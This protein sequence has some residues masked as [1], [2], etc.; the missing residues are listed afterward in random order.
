[1][2][3]SNVKFV[4]PKTAAGTF[5]G[6]AGI[7]GFDSGVLLSCGN[8]ADVVGPNSSD[9]ITTDNNLPGDADL[10]KLIPGYKSYDATILEFGFIP[11]TD[12]IMF[13]YVFGSDEYNEWVNSPFNDVF[14]FFVNQVNY[15]RVAGDPVSINSING[16][17]PLG[18]NASH[19]SFYVNNWDEKNNKGGTLDTEMDGLTVELIFTAPVKRGAKNWLKLAIADA[20]DHV[21]DSNVFLR[22]GSLISAVPIAGTVTTYSGAGIKDVAMAFTASNGSDQYVVLT[23]ANGYFYSAVAPGWSGTLTPSKPGLLFKPVALSYS[24]VYGPYYNQNFIGG[25]LA[26]PDAMIRKKEDATTAYAANDVYN[27]TGEQQ[28]KTQTVSL[29]DTA[30]YLGKVE[31]DGW[32]TQTLAVTA[33]TVPAGWA[34]TYYDK[35]RGGNDVT[36][37]VTGAGG[38]ALPN[39]APGAFKEFRVEVTPDPMLVAPAA[40]DLLITVSNSGSSEQ[41]AVKAVTV[42]EAT[43]QPD[44]LIANATD[45]VYLGNDFYDTLA[46]ITGSG[47]LQTQAQAVLRDTTATY[48]L[49][50]QNDGNCLDDFR[51][52]GTAGHPA[53]TVRYYDALTGGTDI[54]AQVAGGGWTTGTLGPGDIREMR[55]EVTP[56]ASA[57]DGAVWTVIVKATSSIEA[58]CRD[59][60]RADTSV[61]A[62]HQPDMLIRTGG[63]GF[64]GGGIYNTTGAN[65]T[66]TQTRTTGAVAVYGLR[67][68]SPASAR[69]QYPYKVV[70]SASEGGW[71]VR[72]FD[73]LSG[74]TDITSL[75]T[76]AGWWTPPLVAGGTRD[77]RVEVTPHSAVPAGQS[78]EVFVIACSPLDAGIRDAVKAVTTKN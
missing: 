45:G 20:G 59:L 38:W 18:T 15:A 1:V 2:G 74:G 56:T 35:P 57:G 30:V 9:S 41:D 37:Q 16:G 78:K 68:Q 25:P 31:N 40:Y 28:T 42:L 12:A 10:D 24:K 11:T 64:I 19:P 70:G 7:I 54:T 67:V 58:D 14:G 47:Y 44:L 77:L 53:F 46:P 73:A 8:I 63:G 39:M 51:V 34:A 50:V 75:V 23:D 48:W 69:E 36:A 66:A 43:A 60:A 3:I 55:L 65:Q 52:T 32:K 76:G 33:P 72:Y 22:G 17:N 4:G 21:L 5:T 49:G 61:P 71:V 6:G 29:G 27:T 13:R 26:Q 62:S